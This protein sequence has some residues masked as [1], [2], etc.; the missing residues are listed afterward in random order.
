MAQTVNCRLHTTEARARYQNSIPGTGFYPITQVFPSQYRVPMIHTHILF[1]HH[2][3][4]KTTANYSNAKWNTFLSLITIN[5]E[6]VRKIFC[7]VHLKILKAFPLYFYIQIFNLF[8]RITHVI[9]RLIVSECF[10]FLLSGHLPFGATLFPVKA[11]SLLG[12]Y[13]LPIFTVQE[14][15]I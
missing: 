2:R 4:N 5:V 13:S 12:I 10:L 1:I 6:F 3:Y 9:Y 7:D 11:L 15:R 14:I 8:G